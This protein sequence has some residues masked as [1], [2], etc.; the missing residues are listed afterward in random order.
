MLT[1][2]QRH[3]CSSQSLSDYVHIPCRTFYPTQALDIETMYINSYMPQV[4]YSFHCSDFHKTPHHSTNSGV[5]LLTYLLTHLLT[6]LLTPCRTVLLE[7]L[8][9]LQLVKKFPALYGIRRF[10]AA[11][12]SARHPS[13][14]EPVQSSPCPHP[15]S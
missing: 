11:F 13:L 9:G 1:S 3:A 12:T 4:K 14:P 6:Y 10:I 15:I 5:P 2:L 8:T 7:K